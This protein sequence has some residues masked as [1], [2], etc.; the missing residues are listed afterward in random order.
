MFALIV[1][2]IHTRPFAAVSEIGNWYY[3]H[4]LCNLAVPFF[5]ITSG[6]LLFRNFRE[7]SPEENRQAV[8]KYVL[9]ILRMYGIWCVIWLP[10]KVLN[11]YNLGHF[12][13][14]DLLLYLRDLLFVS[15]G[16]ALWYLPALAL[17]VFLVY[18][19]QK[20]LPFSVIVLISGIFYLFGVAISS[21]YTLF[22]DLPLV[23]WYYRLFSTTSNGLLYGF[24][25]VGLGAYLG[26]IPRKKTTAFY[27][28][29]FLVSFATVVLEAY[30]IRRFGYNYQGVVECV[31]V[32]LCALFLF[33]LAEHLPLQPRP[34][35]KTLRTYSTLIYLSH[36][37]II[38]TLKMICGIL[39]YSVNPIVLFF[40]TTAL[41][42]LFSF[43]V[44]RLSASKKWVRA[45]Y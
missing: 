26:N 34:I 35:Y 24:L 27:L 43:C 37:F 28:I 17:G 15:G 14:N 32:P 18:W 7:A 22:A 42:L 40:A 10:W 41:S 3:L 4:T 19:L 6:F 39:D 9:H 20:K 44:Q 33:R 31:F 36:C 5:F 2:S 11:F 38:R 25:F 16:D 29:G 30:Y 1:V 23:D 45:F 13:L 8:R 12:H 21:W